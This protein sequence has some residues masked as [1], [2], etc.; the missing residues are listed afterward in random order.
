MEE[1]GCEGEMAQSKVLIVEDEPNA[2][3]GLAELV[4]SWGYRTETAADG[5]AGLEMVQRWSPAVVVTDLMMPRMDGLQLLDRIG[6]LEEAVAVVVV[7]AHGAIDSAV[8]AMRMGAYDYIQK[9]IDTARLRTIL[10]SA[11]EQATDSGAKETGGVAAVATADRVGALVGSSPEMHTIFQTI[12]R[13]APTNV[14][15]ADYGG[16]RDRQGAGGAGAA[17]AERAAEQAVC[18]GELCGDSGNAD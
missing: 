9:P 15:R 3:A 8:D 14:S 2:R 13:I 16:E 11:V 1:N 10:K 5:A 17:P 12:E 4:A 6:E 7:T 18:G